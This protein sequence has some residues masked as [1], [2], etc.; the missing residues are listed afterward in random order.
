MSRMILE[1]NKIYDPVIVK[2]LKGGVHI[3]TLAGA[4]TLD[5]DMGLL[6]FLDPG[7]ATRV[8]TLPAA[9]LGLLFI[10]TNTADAAEDLT[11]SDPLGPATRGTISQN[12]VGIVY[13]D[14]VR[15][16]VGMMTTT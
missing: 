15:W 13:S 4:T 6:S 2:G 7:G 10:I 11:I 12:E 1:D 5:R 8:L 14:G 16:Y 9:E 3:Q